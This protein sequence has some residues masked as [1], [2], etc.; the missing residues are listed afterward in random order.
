[1][2]SIAIFASGA[3]SNARKI[4]EHFS[5]HPKIRVDLVVCNKPQAG[6]LN[7]ADEHGIPTLILDK[8]QFFRGNAYVDEFKVDDIDFIVLAGFLWK[9]PDALIHAYP[10]KIVNIVCL[11][12]GMISKIS[13]ESV[14]IAVESK[15][16]TDVANPVLDASHSI[17]RVAVYL[18]G[19][20]VEGGMQ[21]RKLQIEIR[22]PL[23]LAYADGLRGL[24]F[25]VRP[26]HGDRPAIGWLDMVGGAVLDLL[27]KSRRCDAGESGAIHHD[28]CTSRNAKTLKQAARR[29]QL[30][31]RHQHATLPLSF[32][33]VGKLPDQAGIVDEQGE[34]AIKVAS[35]LEFEGGEPLMGEAQYIAATICG[36]QEHPERTD[37]PWIDD[38]PVPVG[39][40]NP[41]AGTAADESQKQFQ[42]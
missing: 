40:A 18:I 8:E 26:Q 41:D 4:I 28:R 27:A 39:F 29:F 9:I 11:P 34:I 32:G 13:I 33:A 6:V 35:G 3:G 42:S 37:A 25:V 15:L 21:P 7:I 14:L 36:R 2:K 17:E 12:I 30:G 38:L 31:A 24:R 22:A 10:G 1:M 23:I 19:I 16:G 20:L 5:H